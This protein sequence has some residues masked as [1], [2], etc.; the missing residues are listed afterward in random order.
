MK[1]EIDWQADSRSFNRVAEIYDACRP[2]YPE[3]LV[4]T[5]LRKS[6]ISAGRK[7]LDCGVKPD[8]NKNDIRFQQTL[9]SNIYNLSFLRRQ[10]SIINNT[11]RRF[12]NTIR[13]RE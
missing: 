6:G 13:R 7:I 3:E 11:Q 5:I 8:N 1:T 2:G 9:E 12:S 4:E 10:E